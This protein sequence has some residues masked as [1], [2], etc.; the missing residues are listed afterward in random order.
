M[1]YIMRACT[2][3]LLVVLSSADARADYRCQQLEALSRQYRGVS[4]T[5]EQRQIKRRLVAWYNSNCRS[6]RASR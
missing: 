6:R 2:V 5:S 3:G 1:R 4:L